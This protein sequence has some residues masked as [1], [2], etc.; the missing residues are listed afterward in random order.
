MAQKCH[1][2]SKRVRYPNPSENDWKGRRIAS[3]PSL[4]EWLGSI[5]TG[6][7]RRSILEKAS[8]RGSHRGA[9]KDR[10]FEPFH[11]AWTS[12]RKRWGCWS[13][14]LSKLGPVFF[15][16][17]ASFCF[18]P[19][20][21]CIWPILR[22]ERLNLQTNTGVQHQHHLPSLILRWYFDSPTRHLL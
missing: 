11:M 1:N 22:L 7:N 17:S 20:A 18:T 2:K 4:E 13:G 12:R 8:S 5:L 21:T 10:V 6:E 3:E 16:F 14:G 9:G 19:E 15:F